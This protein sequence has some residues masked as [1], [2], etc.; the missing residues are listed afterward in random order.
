[1]FELTCLTATHAQVILRISGYFSAY[2]S[3]R[4]SPYDFL[5][6]S[7]APIP[8]A[9][10][11]SAKKSHR[12]EAWGNIWAA[13]PIFGGLGSDLDQMMETILGS[14][15]ASGFSLVIARKRLCRQLTEAPSAR[16]IPL[17]DV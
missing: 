11:H 15:S 4:S 9:A 13:K 16:L 6:F 5:A 10:I 1:M 12:E 17:V 7:L 8:R 14:D 2:F 3:D